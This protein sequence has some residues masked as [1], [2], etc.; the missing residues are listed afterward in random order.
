MSLFKDLFGFDFF[1]SV[2]YKDGM[3]A[4]SKEEVQIRQYPF[5]SSQERED[6]INK[7]R[8]W[9]ANELHKR[10]KQDKRKQAVEWLE[11]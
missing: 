5:Y 4:M 7:L 9:Q 10:W 2:F 8:E 11:G 6:K 1:D 3:Q